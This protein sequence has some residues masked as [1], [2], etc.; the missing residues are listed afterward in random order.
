MH[1]K[2]ESKVERDSDLTTN[3]SES[4][5]EELNSGLEVIEEAQV[6][7]TENISVTQVIVGIK[8]T[9]SEIDAINDSSSHGQNLG[10]QC[11]PGTPSLGET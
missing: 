5:E 3:P 8:T 4:E 6:V 10:G 9:E 11:Q 7:P 2:W 1:G